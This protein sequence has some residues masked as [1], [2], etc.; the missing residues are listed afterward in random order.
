MKA[1]VP[2]GTMKRVKAFN[3]YIL[4]S[5]VGGKIYATQDDCGHQRASLAKGA[6]EGSVVTCPLHGAKFDVTTGRN[7]GGVQMRMSPEMM[8]K[9]PPEVMAMFQRTSQIVSDIEILP[10][11]K[12]K[13]EVRGDSVYLDR[14]A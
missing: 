6:L 5:N 9:I 10:L 3:E 14:E 2:V 11:R 7:V 12:F 1:E 8:Q 4:L 13:V